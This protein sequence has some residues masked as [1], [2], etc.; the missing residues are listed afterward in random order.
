MTQ[1]VTTNPRPLCPSARPDMDNS[2]IFG[3]VRRSLA[4]PRVGYLE[5]P[6]PVSN[7]LLALAEPV[8]PTEVFR[9]AATCAGSCCQHFDGSNCRLAT[10]IVLLMPAVVES[11]PPCAIRPHCRW[12][13]QEGKAACRRCPAIVTESYQESESLRRAADPLTPVEELAGER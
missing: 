7:E 10:R 9:F 4:E 3:V 11:L 5:E 1:D 2:V 8:N 12:W 13:Q 6:Q